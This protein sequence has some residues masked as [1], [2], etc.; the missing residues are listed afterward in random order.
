MW[1]GTKALGIE[2]LN[3]KKIVWIAITT[4]SVIYLTTII[5]SALPLFKTVSSYVIG[6]LLTLFILKSIFNLTFQHTLI[7]W[8]INVIAHL[9]SVFISAKLFIG[10]FKDLI[11]II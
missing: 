1:G 9:L 11:E 7:I 3:F 8:G 4:S 2:N 10:G 6:S 5:L